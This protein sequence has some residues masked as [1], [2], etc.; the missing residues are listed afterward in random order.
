MCGAALVDAVFV[1][2]W[3]R[4]LPGASRGVT[5]GLPGYHS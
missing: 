1:F 3:L 2:Q 4:L 5:L